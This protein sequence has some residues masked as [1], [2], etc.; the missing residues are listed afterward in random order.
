MAGS[1]GGHRLVVKK[2]K[3]KARHIKVADD[4]ERKKKHGRARLGKDDN[5]GAR[6]KRRNPKR[7]R[8]SKETL[9]VSKRAPALNNDNSEGDSP[10][11]KRSL[12]SKLKEEVGEDATD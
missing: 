5:K 3:P 11:R 9:V 8:P 1:T 4:G 12:K 2:N 7:K 10:P 6:E